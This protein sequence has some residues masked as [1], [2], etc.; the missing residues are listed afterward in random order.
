M[1]RKPLGHRRRTTRLPA[2]PAPPHLFQPMKTSALSVL[3]PL[4][5]AAAVVSV[6]PFS[7]TSHAAP[8]IYVSSFNNG[9]GSEPAF[10]ADGTAASGYTAPSGFGD[11]E[12]VA[13]DPATNTLYVADAAHN[14]ISTFNA[15]TGAATNIGFASAAGLNQPYG[16]LQVGSN[17]LVANNGNGS[18]T[19]LAFNAANGQA[20]TGFTSPTGLNGPAGLASLG[21]TLFVSNLGNNTVGAYNL[22][23]GGAAV[24]SFTPISGLNG[25]LGL[26]VYGNDLFVAN[27]DGSTVG[28][29]NATTGA[30]INASFVTGLSQP[31]GL[32]VLG[33]NLLAAND[34]GTTVGEY[35]IP[36]T[37]T[38]G[39]TP[40]SSNANFLIGLD[41]PDFIAVVPE[42]S[43]WAFV[44][45][46]VGLL[47]L[48]LRRRIAHV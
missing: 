22:A 30:V 9:S 12:G 37:A 42:P 41:F 38:L 32:A 1:E 6:V 40:T 7:G 15:T 27:N 23:M 31:W 46:G 48:T 13:V 39:N 34:G 10:N 43:T 36:A 2:G 47:G 18:N 21:T 45:A 14:T 26:A 25:P 44:A 17:L 16:M 11:P 28:E 8:T 24:S 19:I 33:G 20:G 5:L 35:G 3:R 29:Y 4:V